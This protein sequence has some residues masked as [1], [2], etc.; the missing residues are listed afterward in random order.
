MSH[1]TFS[2]HFPVGRASHYVNYELGSRR[3]NYLKS[4]F[5]NIT[6]RESWRQPQYLYNT[7]NRLAQRLQRRNFKIYTP[8]R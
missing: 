1:H 8:V 4:V 7:G 3:Y 5:R 2:I 6:V